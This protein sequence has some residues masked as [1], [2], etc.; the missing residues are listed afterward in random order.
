MKNTCPKMPERVLHIS[1]G[2]GVLGGAIRFAINYYKYINQKLVIFDFLFCNRNSLKM[3][4]N[5]TLLDN[6]KIFELNCFEHGMNIRS[7]LSL[8]SNIRRILKDNNYMI[9]HVD[10]GSLP[11]QICC[12]FACRLEKVKVRIA[13]SHSMG[14]IN[15]E[16]SVKSII[17]YLAKPIMQGIIRILATDYFACSNVAGENLFGKR[18]IKSPRYKQIHNA[19][20]VDRF[21]YDVAKREEI[22]DFAQIDKDTVV[23]GHVGRFDKAKNH[24]FLL[25]VFDEIYK[26]NSN[27]KLWIIGD[28]DLRKAIEKKLSALESKQNVLLYGEKNNVSDMLQGIDALIFP[29]IY[30]GLSIVCVEA[31]TSGL[32]IFASQNIS[33]EHNITGNVY[34]IS[35][36]LSAVE[37]AEYIL[38][39]IDPLERKDM[40][41]IIEENGYSLSKEGKKLEDLYI[42]MRERYA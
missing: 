9:V 12:L 11:I 34:F 33:E 37:W 25:D 29:S 10:S 15:K 2:S 40:S 5:D 30:E 14:D 38:Q 6:S 24:L 26:R 16:K 4:E 39:K 19:I 41:T 28:G 23:F 22:R 7:Y 17:K 32:Q 1:Y 36:E 3:L 18:G 27:T 21:R 8:I 13:H 31:Q 35:L 42:N 20:E